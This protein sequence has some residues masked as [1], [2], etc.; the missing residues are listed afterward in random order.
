MD[1][2]VLDETLYL[3]AIIDSYN[4]QFVYANDIIFWS[5]PYIRVKTSNCKYVLAART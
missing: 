2:I 4:E 1:V 3:V 5:K